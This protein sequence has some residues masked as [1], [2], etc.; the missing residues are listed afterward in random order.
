MPA[1]GKTGWHRYIANTAVYAKD[2]THKNDFRIGDL[3]KPRLP[4]WTT[5]MLVVVHAQPSGELKLLHPNKKV[6]WG[7]AQRYE[8][9]QRCPTDIAS[10]MCT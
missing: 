5:D 8:L 10:V 6:R 1:A 3:V 7:L 4:K 9:V 2:M